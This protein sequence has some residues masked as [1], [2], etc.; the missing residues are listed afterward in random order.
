YKRS[1]NQC[2]QLGLEEYNKH[3]KAFNEYMELS[4][5]CP[6]DTEPRPPHITDDWLIIPPEARD[7]RSVKDKP[8]LG[9]RDADGLVHGCED[10]I[11]TVIGDIVYMPGEVEQLIVEQ[12][13]CCKKRTNKRQTRIKR[14]FMDIAKEDMEKHMWEM[15]IIYAFSHDDGDWIK[16]ID[17][18][19]KSLS[20]HT[21]LRFERV[22]K[23]S[24]HDFEFMYHAEWCTSHVGIFWYT[25]T[26]SEDTNISS[27]HV[28]VPWTNCRSVINY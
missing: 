4:I 10:A 25:K 7:K 11:N 19:I 9:T 20:Q 16:I 21:C 6:C 24:V 28:N 8:L 22:D 15:P 26:K 12:R 27:H 23:W 18:A 3:K 1:P 13:R 14:Q 2:D 5:K 17:E